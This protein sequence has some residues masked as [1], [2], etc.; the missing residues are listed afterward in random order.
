MILDNGTIWSLLLDD[1]SHVPLC[2]LVFKD[3]KQSWV[4]SCVKSQQF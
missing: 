2:S 4:Q 1:I 3:T